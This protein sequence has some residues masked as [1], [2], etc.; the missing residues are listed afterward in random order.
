MNQQDRQAIDA[1]FQRI[2][3]VERQGAS[4]DPE[5]EQLIAEHLRAN[6]AAA[7]YLAQT[8]IVQDQALKNG[9][10]EDGITPPHGDTLSAAGTPLRGNPLNNTAQ[11]TATSDGFGQ[12]FGRSAP[13]YAP[14]QPAMSTQFGNS[15]QGGGF[16]AGAAQTAMGVAGGM[17]LGSMLGGMFGAGNAHAAEAGKDQASNTDSTAASDQGSGAGEADAGG[18]GFFDGLFG[19]GDDGGGF[20]DI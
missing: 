20:D 1:L 2:G 5:A 13:N 10:Q 7:Y 6:P 19:G 12:G 9:R 15:A 4:R 11:N 8:V 14:Q 16:L 18:G 3:D 17:M